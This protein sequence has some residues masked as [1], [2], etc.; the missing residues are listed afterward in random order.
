MADDVRIELPKGE[1]IE[2]AAGPLTDCLVCPMD[3]CYYLY[4]ATSPATAY[5]PAADNGHFLPAHYDYNAVP[6]EAQSFWVMC[7]ADDSLIWKAEREP[8]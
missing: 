4:S 6:E 8:A 1:W 7:P 3:D 5:T 2:V